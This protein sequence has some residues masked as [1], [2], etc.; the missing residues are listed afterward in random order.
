MYI[1]KSLTNEHVNNLNLNPSTLSWSAI[2]LLLRP[3]L[4]VT[5]QPTGAQVEGD[6]QVQHLQKV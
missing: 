3:F 4:L 1:Y 2:K 5:L 6:E